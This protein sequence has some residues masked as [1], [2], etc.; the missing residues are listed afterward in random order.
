MNRNS[1]YVDEDSAV[2]IGLN[3]QDLDMSK[4]DKR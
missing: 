3:V 4:E 2:C 1:T